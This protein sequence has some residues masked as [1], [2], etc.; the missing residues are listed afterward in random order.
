MLKHKFSKFY[1]IY[2]VLEESVLQEKVFFLV[3][4]N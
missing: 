1:P 4:T 2:L 3:Y